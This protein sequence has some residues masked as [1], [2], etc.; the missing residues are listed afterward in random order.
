MKRM[1]FSLAMLSLVSNTVFSELYASAVRGPILGKSDLGVLQQL[2]EIKD[3]RVG[4]E[5]KNFVDE[6]KLKPIARDLGVS[7]ENLTRV[8]AYSWVEC[9]N[10]KGQT[11]DERKCIIIDIIRSKFSHDKQLQK[12]ERDRKDLQAQLVEK[13][14]I[15]GL[16]NW[17]APTK[18]TIVITI[19]DPQ[20]ISKANNSGNITQ[21]RL[22]A[23]K[24]GIRMIEDANVG[25]LT[26]FLPQLEQILHIIA[27][28]RA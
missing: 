19:I 1:P 18:E 10:G 21:E 14:S 23:L 6:E 13:L 15:P 17:D 2:Q 4:P 8:C 24:A 16:I 22:D 11:D 20:G 26:H 12:L 27:L 28:I 25:T 3:R 5:Y 7:V 9:L